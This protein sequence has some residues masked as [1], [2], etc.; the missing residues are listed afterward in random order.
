MQSDPSKHRV[1]WHNVNLVAPH[2]ASR[3]QHWAQLTAASVPAYPPALPTFLEP[4]LK[5]QLL[6]LPLVKVSDS[7]SCA[8]SFSEPLA[9]RMADLLSMNQPVEPPVLQ[10]YASLNF[11]PHQWDLVS[12]FMAAAAIEDRLSA[13]STLCTQNMRPGDDNGRVVGHG[14][15]R[16]SAPIQPHRLACVAMP[17]QSGCANSCRQEQVCWHAIGTAS[18]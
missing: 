1:Q 17:S 8:C 13:A 6:Q 11:T 12:M 9:A 18:S 10:Q 5:T 14:T 4:A 2:R 15:S 3:P 16:T 7:C